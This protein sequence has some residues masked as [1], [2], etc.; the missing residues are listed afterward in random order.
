MI[1]T[2]FWLNG[3]RKWKEL[4]FWTVFYTY[5][6]LFTKTYFQTLDLK[7]TQGQWSIAKWPFS[8]L[9]IGY[10]FFITHSLCQKW[11]ICT[12]GISRLFKIDFFLWM[13][14][15]LLCGFILKFIYCSRIKLHARHWIKNRKNRSFVIKISYV[16]L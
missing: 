3:R 7:I 9:T 14:T 13:C 8:Y 5:C 16:G 15:M 12:D 4:I 2:N 6:S 11:H 1:K 10:I